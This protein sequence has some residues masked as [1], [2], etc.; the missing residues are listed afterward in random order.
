MIA[1]ANGISPT[2]PSLRL[3]EADFL[4]SSGGAAVAWCGRAATALYWAYR[5]AQTSNAE[6]TQAEVIMPAISC[7]TPANV[8]LLA[9]L[10][11]RFAD[12]DSHTGLISLESIQAR[13]TPRTCAV[14]FIHLFGQTAN[15]APIVEW[16][17]SKNIVL[18]EDVAQALGARLPDG[19]FVGSAGDVSV[20]SFNKTKILEC[21]G[22][23]LLLRSKD[24]TARLEEVLRKS[25]LPA[26]MG[27]D[28]A[29]FLAQSY[30]NLH[31]ALVALFRLHTDSGVSNLFLRVRAA[32]D[33][34][35]LRSM[36]DPVALARA[37][38]GLPALVE[39]RYQKADTYAEKL[40]G[41]PWHLLDAWRESGVCWR[42][43]LLVNFADPFFAFSESVRRDGFHVSN[44]YWPVNQFFCPDDACPNAD[45]FAHRIVNL[46]VDD[47]VDI[48][49]VQRC[50][51]SLWKRA[52]QFQAKDAS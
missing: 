45:S 26:E 38:Q 12:V 31:H 17:R 46:W 44:L 47:S 22:G 49:W 40:W 8:A 42:Y 34:L 13:W 35:L 51:D 10:L 41:G 11:P 3:V 30:R 33:G 32:Y 28:T 14:V 36:K 48:K 23:A 16:C 9:G 37:W 39:R 52:E 2:P 5:V 6:T 50:G 43:S 25:P 20:Y 4:H 29:A 24:L 7:A 21:G 27:P 19:R 18:I 1:D 15:L